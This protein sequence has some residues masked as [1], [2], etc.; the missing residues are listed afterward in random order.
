ML[1]VGPWNDCLAGA[2]A[3]VSSRIYISHGLKELFGGCGS[4]AR[5]VAMLRIHQLPCARMYTYAYT[6]T[7]SERERERERERHTHT[8]TPAHTHTIQAHAEHARL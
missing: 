1:P 7:Q 5:V 3:C 8:H 4:F 6:Y 2:R